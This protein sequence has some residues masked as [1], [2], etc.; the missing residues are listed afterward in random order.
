MRQEDAM[1]FPVRDC[2]DESACYEKLK[3]LLHPGGFRCPRCRNA[4]GIGVHRYR[5]EHVPDHRCDGCGRVFNLFTQTR[6]EGIRRDPSEIV[7]ILRGIAQGTPTA[8]LAREL[9][10]D[11][12][13]LLKLRHQIQG[14]AQAALPNGGL[15]DPVTEA[16]E[17][18]Q[19]AGEKRDSAQRPGRSAASAGQQAAG[20]RHLGQRPAGAGRGRRPEVGADPAAARPAHRQGDA[21]AVRGAEHGSRVHGQHR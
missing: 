9:G 18:F 4:G 21:A 12:T 3:G 2:M 6:L 8:K 16:D 17:M 7:L 13:A 1:D 15:S 10:C 5:R 19:N 14:W 20:P 11:R